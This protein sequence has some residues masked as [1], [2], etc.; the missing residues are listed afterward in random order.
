VEAHGGD[1]AAFLGDDFMVTFASP[2]DGLRCAMAIQEGL[3]RRANALLNGG[4]R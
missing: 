2:A 1:E 3:Q 4:H